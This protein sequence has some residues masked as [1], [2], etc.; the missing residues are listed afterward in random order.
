MDNTSSSCLKL[1]GFCLPCEIDEVSAQRVSLGA[2]MVQKIF[3]FFYDRVSGVS[4]MVVQKLAQGQVLDASFLD[5][6][7]KGEFQNKR[8]CHLEPDWVRI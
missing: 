5:H 6:P 3:L 4:H 7:L 2:F 1:C 8:D